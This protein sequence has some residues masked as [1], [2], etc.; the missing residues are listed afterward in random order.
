MYF[1]YFIFSERKH[2]ANFQV[3]QK[4]LSRRPNGGSSSSRDSISYALLDAAKQKSFLNAF[5]KTGYKSSSNE[6]LIAYK[7]RRGK[8]SVFKGEMRIEE[9][10][11]F[12]GSVLS[13]DISFREMRG[14]PVLEH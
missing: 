2:C 7:P 3:S 13:G 14:K 12:I 10:E 6:L 5:D 11:G 8:Y 4:S 9:V 1:F